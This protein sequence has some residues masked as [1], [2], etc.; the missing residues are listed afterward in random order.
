[1]GGC[2]TGCLVEGRSITLVPRLVA[3][4]ARQA[5]ALP[6]HPLAVGLPKAYRVGHCTKQGNGLTGDLHLSQERLFLF[7]SSSRGPE[8]APGFFCD[9]ICNGA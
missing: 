2:A 4:E 9:Q 7:L 5:W 3:L 1:M 6:A 8:H